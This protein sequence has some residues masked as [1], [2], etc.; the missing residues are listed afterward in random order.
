MST[1]TTNP[2]ATHP[3]PIRACPRQGVRPCASVV[4]SPL[5]PNPE[6]NVIRVPPT[7]NRAHLRKLT[8]VFPTTCNSDTQN[9]S[10]L[11]PVFSISSALFC[12]FVH[13]IF[14]RNPLVF[15]QICTLSKKH[16]GWGYPPPS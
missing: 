6:T 11:N 16:R 10:D 13:P 7:R 14:P 2:R 5:R 1:P 15:Y 9:N 4:N 8:P 3:L 12:A